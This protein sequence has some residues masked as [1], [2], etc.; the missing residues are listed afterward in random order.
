M[1]EPEHSRSPSPASGLEDSYI[2]D[3][4][5][6][7]TLPATPTVTVPTDDDIVM[8]DRTPR[9]SPST[10]ALPTSSKVGPSTSQKVTT[11]AR[12][13]TAPYLFPKAPRENSK[14]S[15][16]DPLK[17]RIPK[18]NTKLVNEGPAT[19]A[20]ILSN[21]AP[22]PQTPIH[23][24]ESS[25]DYPTPPALV[26]INTTNDAT[27]ENQGETAETPL[28]IPQPTPADNTHDSTPPHFPHQCSPTERC[29][30]G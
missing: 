7:G 5:D 6:L 25:G 11:R 17:I 13:S 22:R 20:S 29:Y 23:A 24:V 2:S 28:A 21:P 15:G 18:I 3:M 9:Q 19:Y 16:K 12:L 14:D 10:G 26:P 4:T 8:D 1:S 27:T 30:Y